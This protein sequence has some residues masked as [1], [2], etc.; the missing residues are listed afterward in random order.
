M[1]PFSNREILFVLGGLFLLAVVAL[2]G[3]VYLAVRFLRREEQSS[4]G[5]GFGGCALAAAFGCLGTCAL[6]AIGVL[7]VVVIGTRLFHFVAERV[8]GTHWRIERVESTPQSESAELTFRARGAHVDFEPVLA[9][10]R[11]VA[12]EVS[13]TTLS[14]REGSGGTASSELRVTIGASGAELLR[15]ESE[16]QARTAGLRLPD[17]SEIEYLG[18][19]R[20]V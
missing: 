20:D 5:V 16:I 4:A 13:R 2:G 6:V 1:H 15:I 8:P 3:L 7:V 17:G 18:V 12:G 19:R 9:I 14:T 11:E 10:V